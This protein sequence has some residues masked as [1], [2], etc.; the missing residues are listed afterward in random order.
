MHSDALLQNCI[1][2][3]DDMLESLQSLVDSRISHILYESVY[4]YI[5]IDD[6]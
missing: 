4:Q 6:K 1:S 3:I 2:F 5:E